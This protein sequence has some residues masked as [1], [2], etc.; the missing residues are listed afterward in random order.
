MAA[1]LGDSGVKKQQ[2]GRAP[3]R[4]TLASRQ[5]RRRW[6]SRRRANWVRRIGLRPPV[7][8]RVLLAAALLAVLLF[9]PGP[10]SGGSPAQQGCRGCRAQPAVA[11]EWAVRLTGPWSAGAVTGS[12]AAMSAGDGS[13]VPA[14]GQG[15]VAVG[16]G[17]A[18][19]GSG[20]SLTGY[21]LAKRMQLW[22]VTLDAPFGSAI[23]SVRA[24]PGVVTAG[25]LAPSGRTRTE[26]VLD[27]TTGAQVR[28]YQAALFGGAVTASAQA[29]VIVGPA[30]VTSYDNRTGRVR[31]QHATTPG[32]PWRTDGQDLFLAES[33]GG[34][35]GSSPVTALKVINL[36][37]GAERELGSPLGS[38]F[39][40]TLATASDGVVL[41]A[42]A[43]GVTAYSGS[44]GGALWSM[45]AAVL[46]GTDPTAKLLYLTSGNGSLTGVDPLT[47]HVKT[48]V[49]GSAAGSAGIYVVRDGVALGLDSGANG[50]AWGYSLTAGRVTWTSAALP[51]PHF[52]SDVS[53]L[54]GSAAVSGNVVVVTACLHLATT[55]GI[56]AEPELVVIAL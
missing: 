46:E 32:E 52:F 2:R 29:T 6:A 27:A 48:S 26:V 12:G 21:S 20:L 49:A 30:S 47:G 35:L 15:Y 11:Q 34:G 3:R 1:E 53:G 22:Q 40:G 5:G 51:W 13:T 25:I 9:L 18:V 28:H 55:P 10:A 16:G 36:S 23:I 4:P 14:F 42:S 44:T 56:C 41:F 45:P 19:L 8:R 17:I 38:P 24:W 33:A 54:G 50:T 31:W 7:A 43:S 37:M 39:S